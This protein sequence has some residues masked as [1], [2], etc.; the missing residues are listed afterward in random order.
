MRCVSTY[1][2][3]AGSAHERATRRIDAPVQCG[4]SDSR[5]APLNGEASYSGEVFHENMRD[6]PGRLTGV[7]NEQAQC[8][9]H[10]RAEQPSPMGTARCSVPHAPHARRPHRH[11]RAELRGDDG[12]AT[13]AAAPRYQVA[14]RVRASECE[15][16]CQKYARGHS[17]ADLHCGRDERVTLVQVPING[18]TNARCERSRNNIKLEPLPGAC[19]PRRV[20][21]VHAVHG[22]GKKGLGEWLCFQC[23]R[24]SEPSSRPELGNP[25]YYAQ[26][27]MPK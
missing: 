1:T 4:G 21:A 11:A 24:S 3:R 27:S 13:G 8:E 5:G 26:L 10:A 9:A 17:W 16:A 6:A 15:G 18:Q 23:T 20:R 19:E 14:L 22:T 7:M 25:A 12:H 2:H